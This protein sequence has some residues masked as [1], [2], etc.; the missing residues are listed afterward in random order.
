VSITV[1]FISTLPD[2]CLIKLAGEQ[3]REYLH[4]QLTVAT[5]HFDANSARLAAHCDFKGKMFSALIVSEFEDAFLLA[6]Q[7][8]AAQ[9]SL[10]QLKKYGVFSKVDIA[11][12]ED[13]KA[14]GGFGAEAFEKIKALFIDLNNTHMGASANEFGQVI[15]FDDNTLRFVAYL[16]KEGQS[17]LQDLC[18]QEI[19]DQSFLFEVLEI[20]AGLANVQAQ[21]LGE[22]VPQML[23][24]H[25]LNAID[26]DKGCYMGQEVVARTK[27]LG[28]NKRA[29]FILSGLL[30]GDEDLAVLKVGNTLERQ[31]GDN[32]RRSG[33]INRVSVVD[34][35]V[36]LLAVMAKDTEIDSQIRIKDSDI[37]L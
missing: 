30:K 37:V 3:R 11:F 26:F 15:V 27:F 31:L 32:W 17:R 20:K 12:C 29:T 25:A 10:N 5:K 16:N 9:E 2:L 36:H 14:Y 19:Q 7:K 22:F 34:K 8:D 24:F 6:A 13:L 1:S 33:I 4:G 18:E 35:H 23:N 28:K 21:T